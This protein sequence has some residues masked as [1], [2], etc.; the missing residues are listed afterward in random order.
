[1][2]W[3]ICETA[4]K[5][6]PVVT[7]DLIG[8]LVPVTYFAFLV[9]ERACGRRGRFRHAGAGDGSASGSL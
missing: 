7:V 9:T 8:L 1:M 2:V 4:S 5:G 6:G 3:P